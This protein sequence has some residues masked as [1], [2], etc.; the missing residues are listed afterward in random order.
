[1]KQWQECCLILF[2]DMQ[3]LDHILGLNAEE[4]EWYQMVLRAIVAY[5]AALTYIRIAGMRSFGTSSAFDVV[6]TITMGAVLSRTITGHYP[7]FPCLI[8]AFVLAFVHRLIALVSFKSRVVRKLVEG[9]PVLLFSNG[10]FVEKNLSLHSI[11]RP[12][13]ERTL[14]EEGIDNYDKVKSI[15]YEVDGKISV[16]TKDQ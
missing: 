6:V 10:L 4:L 12:D 9:N 15:W 16:V 7:F 11:S 13:L 2:I 14:R 3:W 1:L 5:V 8:T